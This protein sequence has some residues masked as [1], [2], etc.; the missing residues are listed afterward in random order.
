LTF[1]GPNDICFP[2]RHFRAQKSLDFEG[3]PL[4]L[5][6]VMDLARLKTI[7]YHTIKTTGTLIV[8]TVVNTKRCD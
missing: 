7:M 1:V 2:Y 8:I 4:P 3:P 5:P 6:L